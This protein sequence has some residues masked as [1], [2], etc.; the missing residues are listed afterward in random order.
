MASQ[1]LVLLMGDRLIAEENDLVGRDGLVQMLYLG[2]AER[3]G[4][5]DPG[6]KGTDPLRQRLHLQGL[7]SHRFSPYRVQA[8]SDAPSPRPTVMIVACRR[9]ISLTNVRI[10]AA[11]VLV[12]SGAY[13]DAHDYLLQAGKVA[14]TR[15][16]LLNLGQNGVSIF[17]AGN[18]TRV[19]MSEAETLQPA[20]ELL[21]G[22]VLLCTSDGSA[23]ENARSDLAQWPPSR[24]A[25]FRTETERVSHFGIS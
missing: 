25:V 14:E 20:R 22:L 23:R 10:V 18:V 1:R 2:V 9:A 7:A 13:P 16:K 12:R 8:A 5:V 11:P 17:D 21:S 4:Q 15:V 24:P 6:D 19:N 3:L